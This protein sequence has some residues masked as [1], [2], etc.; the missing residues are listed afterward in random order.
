[1]FFMVSK[2]YQF[3]KSLKYPLQ[4]HVD[5]KIKEQNILRMR[6][7]AVLISKN[8][9]TLKILNS[10]Q[11]HV[12]PISLCEQRPSEQQNNL[13]PHELGLSHDFGVVSVHLLGPPPPL[14]FT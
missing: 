6:G 11:N 9:V 3:I 13:S 10:A 8:H 12:Q 7:T 1:M 4:F 14:G 2:K 5:K